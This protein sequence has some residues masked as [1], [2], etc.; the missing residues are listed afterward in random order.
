MMA[1]TL[2]DRFGLLRGCVPMRTI[3]RGE[4]A[5]LC[6][7]L[8][9]TDVARERLRAWCEAGGLDRPAP[10][11]AQAL[12]FYGDSEMFSPVVEA[13]NRMAPPARDFVLAHALVLGTGWTTAGWTGSAS[14]ARERSRVIL[15]SGASRDADAVMRTT[16]HEAAHVWCE[17]ET[18]GLVSA[19]GEGALELLAYTEGW[20]DQIRHHRRRIEF[21]A[22]SLAKRWQ[23]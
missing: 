8:A 10:E 1:L 3:A 9:A 13:F 2:A 19:V 12:R 7:E 22:C 21:R 18:E 11:L 20:H 23:S 5:W 4:P 16:L 17:P 14:F 6:N 15:L